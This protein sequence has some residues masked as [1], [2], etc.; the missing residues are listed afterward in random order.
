MKSKKV[1]K[2][3]NLP[4]RSPILGTIVYVLAMDYWNAPQWF[5]GVAISFMALIWIAWIALLIMEEGVDVINDKRT[6]TR[7]LSFREKL[8]KAVDQNK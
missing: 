1:I 8:E 5:W 7:K 6:Y 3:S 4:A 2:K